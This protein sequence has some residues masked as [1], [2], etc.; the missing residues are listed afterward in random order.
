L[1]YDRSVA[2]EQHPVL[3]MPV[4]GS[5]ER[6]AL[7]VA[8]TGSNQ[9][10]SIYL[11]YRIGNVSTISK[12]YQGVTVGSVAQPKCQNSLF[13]RDLR[14]LEYASSNQG[15]RG[16]NPFGS[17]FYQS[18]FPDTWVTPSLR[19]LVDDYSDAGEVLDQRVR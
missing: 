9:C 7:G 15:V 12:P 6:K 14:R 5:C 17:T 11:C 4:H 8:E 13:Y 18:L 1:K 16:S 3:S 2:V 10:G 19:F